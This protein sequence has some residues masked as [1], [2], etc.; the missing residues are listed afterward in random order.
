MNLVHSIFENADRS[1]VALV[2]GDE[3]ISYGRLI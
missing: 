1:A 2:C 3:E